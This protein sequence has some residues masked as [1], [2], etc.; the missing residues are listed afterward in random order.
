MKLSKALTRTAR[1]I[2]VGVVL[3]VLAAAIVS[4]VMALCGVMT[5]EFVTMCLLVLF[6]CV[7]LISL[8]CIVQFHLGELP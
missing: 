2:M 1:D 5:M 4:G 3:I 6:V 8:G 7:V